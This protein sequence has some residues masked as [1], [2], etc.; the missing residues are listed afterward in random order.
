M[1]AVRIKLDE[2]L[3]R[4]HADLLRAAG[5]DTE[6]VYEEGLSGET[7]DVVWQHAIAEGR[8]LITLDLDFSDVRR[9]RPGTHPGILLLRPRSRGRQAVLDVLARV[10]RE[11]TL[12]RLSGCLAVADEK[13]TRIRSSEGTD[14]R[15]RS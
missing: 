5:C 7:D 14:D 8:L 4:A 12:E 11:H 2:N 13:S 15:P 1:S 3:A 10:L 6:R 9:F